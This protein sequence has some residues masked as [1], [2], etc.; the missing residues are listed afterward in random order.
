MAEQVGS[1][2][3]KLAAEIAD[4][5]N[6]MQKATRVLNDNVSKMQ[7]GLR[8]LNT[9][10]A[11]V[12]VGFLVN[13][14]QDL[15]GQ[16][17]KTADKFNQ[18]KGRV[19]NS[20]D[21]VNEFGSTFEQL[22]QSSNRTGASLDTVAQAF[23]RLR[24]A[25]EE[26]GKTNADLIRFN[27]TF[28][29]MGAL[30]GATSEELRNAMIQLSQGLSSGALRGDELRSVMEQ[31]PTVARTIADSMGIPFRDF[32]KAAEDGQI[33]AEAVFKAIIDKAD[34]TDASFSKLPGSVDRA[35]TRI[36]NSLSLMIDKLNESWGV[37]ED[38]STSMQNLADEIE[39]T[40][41]KV[42]DNWQMMDQLD[43]IKNNLISTGKNLWGV[44]V[45]LW[46]SFEDLWKVLDWGRSPIQF[47]IDGIDSLT[48]FI[49]KLTIGARLATG[50]V[51]ALFGAMQRIG[52][53]TSMA[54]LSQRS[55][56]LAALV[57]EPAIEAFAPLA[58]PNRS[59][60]RRVLSSYSGTDKKKKGRTARAQKSEAEKELDRLKQKAE[61]L[62]ESMRKPWEIFNEGITEAEKLLKLHLISMETYNRVVEDLGKK[63]DDMIK[64]EGVAEAMDKFMAPID[65]GADSILEDFADGLDKV[66][67]TVSR[68]ADVLNT[69]KTPLQ[70]YNE[71]MINLAQ[72]YNEG[73]IN[74][75]QF[76]LAVDK[77]KT[78]ST[79]QLGDMESA[80]FSMGTAFEQTFLQFTQTGKF[81]FSDMIS[82]MLNDLS[83]LVF[84]MGVIQPL[85]GGAQ[86]NGGKGGLFT[87][88][89][90]SALGGLFG[91]GGSKVKMYDYSFGPAFAN[92]GQ[93]PANRTFM[94]GER[95]PELMSFDRPGYVTPN[96]ELGSMMSGGGGGVVVNQSINVTTGVQQTVRAEIAQMMPD[97]QKQTTNAVA[98][99]ISRGK[100]M[101]KAVGVRS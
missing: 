60:G 69:I 39:N 32:K 98:Q 78:D 26:L 100:Q 24:P 62:R 87:N 38:L 81:A 10:L 70:A 37:T 2:F 30:A 52:T 8:G 89:I 25:A 40:T 99:A 51:E 29:K 82:S 15:G 50:S 28:L 7:R 96:H 55:D 61:S 42:D 93:T 56:E 72:L 44:I 6:D 92:G 17:V 33:T 57:K 59:T 11:A 83:R 97:I 14:L 65:A 16:L 101:A 4:F 31:M 36:G 53:G 58:I 76:N 75:E 67:D 68:Q 63:T 21:S 3:I 88:L 84:Q 41:Q 94:V 22:I 48:W 90:G 23:V 74:A 86:S 46:R 66:N 54:Y 95:G 47:V 27:E 64:V 45:D 79:K 77:L 35:M 12:G 5:K 73:W 18:L 91:G 71:Q 43:G 1:I 80:I 9:A 13:R 49:D 20:L 19:K 85:F 34:E